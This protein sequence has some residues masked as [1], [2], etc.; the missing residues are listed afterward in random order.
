MIIL[1]FL[2]KMFAADVEGRSWATSS[3]RD[4]MDVTDFSPMEVGRSPM[5]VGR[6]KK[7]F[8]AMVAVIKNFLTVLGVAISYFLIRKKS[9][10]SRNIGEIELGINSETDFFIV[11]AQ[12]AVIVLLPILKPPAIESEHCCTKSILYLK[13]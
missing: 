4:V 11:G 6:R 7:E 13:P 3:V 8:L 12:R 2:Q 5:E 1:R 10:I 9:V